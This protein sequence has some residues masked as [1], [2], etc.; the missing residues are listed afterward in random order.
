MTYC[1]QLLDLS[2]P[3]V[4]IHDQASH[5]LEL[6]SQ[7]QLE[8][9]PVLNGLHFM[10]MVAEED[11]IDLDG[12]LEMISLQDQLTKNFVHSADHFLIAL[13]FRAKHYTE[14]IPVLNERNEWEG[15]ISITKLF[16]Q[17]ATLTGVASPG[18]M[19]VMEVSRHDYALGEINRLVE[20]NDAMIMQV[21]TIP[22]PLSEQIQV[23]L[24]INKEDISDV[25]ATF[26]RH[27]YHVLYYYGD[28]TYQNSLQSNLDHLLNYLNI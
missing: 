19:I 15:I 10:G 18:S 27:E 11:L 25:V 12:T 7:H 5:V 13:R 1:S 24:H 6:M 14:A 21:N 28:E 20:S 3:T 2:Y 16:D 22:D 4:D 17:V 26:Q 23:I 9:L 8:T